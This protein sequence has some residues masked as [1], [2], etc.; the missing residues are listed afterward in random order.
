MKTTFDREIGALDQLVNAVYPK[1]QQLAADA[2]SLGS[3]KQRL[4]PLFDALPPNVCLSLGT[5]RKLGLS[6]TEL[7]YAARESWQRLAPPLFGA[8]P[9]PLA[10]R[11][12]AE[13][14]AALQR[15]VNLCSELI[16]ELW[17]YSPRSFGTADPRPLMSNE[18][19][20]HP[21]RPFAVTLPRNESPCYLIQYARQ[22]L[23]PLVV[24]LQLWPANADQPEWTLEVEGKRVPL[25]ELPEPFLAQARRLFNAGPAMIAFD[26]ALALVQAP[27]VDQVHRA[28]SAFEAGELGVVT[29]VPKDLLD[30]LRMQLVPPGFMP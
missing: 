9:L 4:D 20:G 11:T 25:R 2:N 17:L 10:D 3:A 23:T 6:E 13:S 7:A 28:I 26:E 21:G 29:D 14:K 5:L 15:A 27:L 16:C 8:E 24:E 12:P 18:R 22:H 19:P 1:L 30:S